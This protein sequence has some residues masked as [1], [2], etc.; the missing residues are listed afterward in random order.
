MLS[1]ERVNTTHSGIPTIEGYVKVAAI[2]AGD[3]MEPGKTVGES[4]GVDK[5]SMLS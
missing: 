1:V 3:L 2:V 4:I 5:V